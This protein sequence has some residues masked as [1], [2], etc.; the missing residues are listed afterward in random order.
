M[1]R[2]MLISTFALA[3]LLGGSLSRAQTPAA[4]NCAD[5]T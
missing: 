2:R 1:I 3:A 4:Q 5:L